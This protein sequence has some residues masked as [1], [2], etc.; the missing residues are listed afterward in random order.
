MTCSEAWTWR[1]CEVLVGRQKSWWDEGAAVPRS[2]RSGAG[3]PAQ[4]ESEVVRR[5]GEV[6]RP[7][8]PDS[9]PAVLQA[10]GGVLGRDA[11]LGLVGDQGDAGV[12]VTGRLLA[13]LGVRHDGV[14]ALGGHLQRVLLRSGRDLAVLD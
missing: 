8:E 7:P 14:D 4:G 2:G 6:V 10:E 12:G 5:K 13:A 1:S 3:R 9:A 11:R